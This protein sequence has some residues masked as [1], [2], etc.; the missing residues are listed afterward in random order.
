MKRTYVLLAD[1][2]ET[3]EAMAPVDVLRRC[4]VET[5]T[6]ATGASKHVKSSHKITVEADMLLGDGLALHNGDALVL[7]GGYPGYEN[8]ANNPVVGELAKYYYE[9]NRLLAAI[10]GGPT[11]LNRYDIALGKKIT[12]HSSVEAIVAKRYELTQD[13]VCQDGNLITGKG[14]GLALQFSIAVA[15]QLVDN[16]TIATLLHGL[17]IKG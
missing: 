1:G 2:F 6:V 16:D 13:D 3:I 14:A 15:K 11:V 4:G 8:L 9:N 5:I 12:C 17:Q 7:P 10:C